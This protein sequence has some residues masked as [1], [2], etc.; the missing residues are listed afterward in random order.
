MARE[1]RVPAHPRASGVED[2]DFGDRLRRGDRDAFAEVFQRHR[3]AIRAA[4]ASYAKTD[5]EIEDLLQETFLRALRAIDSFR[6]ESSIFTWLYRIAVNAALNRARSR[7]RERTVSVEQVDLI[8]NALGTGRMA[9]RE[10]R[11]RL[12]AALERLPPKQRTVVELRL[13]HEMPFRA[14]ASLAECS[15]E[16]A[17]ANFRHAVK[18]LRELAGDPSLG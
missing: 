18:K 2:G 3:E 14:I 1:P 13:V 6:G 16:S 15:E 12:A 11:R 9:A 10:A 8:T 17:R 4:L 5:D 7:N